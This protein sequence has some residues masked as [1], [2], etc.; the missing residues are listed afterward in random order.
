MLFKLHI[1]RLEQLQAFWRSRKRAAFNKQRENVGVT[2]STI[3]RQLQAL[4]ADLGLQLFHRVAQA[5]LTLGVS[6]SCPVPAK[7]AMSGAM[8]QRN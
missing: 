5:K 8:P 7:F 2:Q 1:M 3:S 6:A 4:E